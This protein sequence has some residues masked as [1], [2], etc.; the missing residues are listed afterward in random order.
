M[1]IGDISMH[2]CIY[3]DMSH[4]CL[5]II[6]IAVSRRMET[7]HYYCEGKD[8]VEEMDF[9]HPPQTTYIVRSMYC[10]LCLDSHREE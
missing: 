6:S 7:M 3:V 1:R 2:A 9:E 4:M 10:K 5:C 8:L